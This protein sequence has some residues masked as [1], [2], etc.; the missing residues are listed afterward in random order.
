MGLYEALVRPAL[1]S[2]EPEKAHNLGLW[3]ISKGFV[4]GRLGPSEPCTVFGVSFPNPVGLAAGFDKNGE[5]LDHWKKLGFGFIEV[6]TVTRHAQPGNPKPRLF[7]LKS[8]LAIINRMGFNNHGADALAS[9]LERSH[10]GIPVGV[11]IGKSKI[12]P[13]EEAASDYQYSFRRLAHLADYVV[14]NVSSPNTPG[15]R[16]LQDREPLTEIMAGLREIDPD[17]PLFVK[18][19][20]DLDEAGLDDVLSVVEN[21]NLTGIVATNTTL[22]REGLAQNSSESGGLSG[23]PL[24]N[25]A[26]QVLT[27][28]RSRSSD[29][30]LIGVGGI[31]DPVTA[32]DRLAAGANLIQVYTGWVFGGPSF[33]A[34]IVE[35]LV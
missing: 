2:L 29:I 4:S 13:I 6:G 9:R 12:T 10:P 17:K 16:G 7:R 35:G 27:H 33:V 31:T 15:L 22:S 24:T 19:A 30:V 14:V 28:L 18:I 5:A 1:F 26:Q 25:R 3:A 11:N 8:D 23:R 20:P 32:R 21:C 34:E